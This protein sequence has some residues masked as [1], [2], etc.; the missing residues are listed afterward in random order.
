MGRR[1]GR[2][3]DRTGLSLR[4]PWDPARVTR[5]AGVAPA[6]HPLL[7]ARAKAGRPWPRLQR[8]HHPELELCRKVTCGHTAAV[9]LHYPKQASSV[10]QHD[11][12]VRITWCQDHLRLRSPAITLCVFGSS[13]SR[14]AATILPF[15]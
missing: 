3:Q 13:A 6:S 7:I 4:L 2:W 14:V 8:H 12:G 15:G 11:P 10:R 5:S 9:R 1:G